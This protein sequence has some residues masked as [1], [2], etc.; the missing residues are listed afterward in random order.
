MFKLFQVQLK[1]GD[2]KVVV[3][4]SIA[5]VAGV[6]YA[7][8]RSYEVS[9]INTISLT[10]T[11]DFVLTAPQATS[12]EFK[13]VPAHIPGPS[14]ASQTASQ[15][16]DKQQQEAELEKKFFA[17]MAENIANRGVAIPQADGE[18]RVPDDF[19]EITRDQDF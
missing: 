6:Q 13:N 19:G 10:G 17:W 2:F 12:P 18:V 15:A 8:R 5:Q 3:A 9:E 1:S 4:E 16:V 14:D 11:I 7:D